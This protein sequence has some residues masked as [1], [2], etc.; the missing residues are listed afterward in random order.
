MPAPEDIITKAVR[1]I[2]QGQYEDAIRLLR[3]YLKDHPE[4]LEGWYNL[5]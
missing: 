2:K 5:G 1:L 4:S 3:A